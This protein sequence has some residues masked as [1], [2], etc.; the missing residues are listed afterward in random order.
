MAIGAAAAV[1]L[2]YLGAMGTWQAPFGQRL[3]YW[4]VVVLPG[5]LLG[6]FVAV[7]VRFWGRFA[8]YRWL[9]ILI[10]AVAVSV[11]H[12][13]LVIVASALF[14]DVDMITPLVV[15]QFWLVVLVL[16]LVLTSINFMASG[17]DQRAPRPPAPAATPPPAPA[18]AQAAATQELPVMPAS[19][20]QRLPPRLQT[21]RL[22]AIAAEDHYL[23]VHTDLGNDLI[24]MRMTDACA[25]LAD[26]PGARVHRSWWLARAAAAAR[27][28]QDGRMLI[29]LV[30]GQTVPVSRAKQ[31]ELKRDGW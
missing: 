23:R 11:P 25:M 15:V 19:L 20:A 18:A 17:G 5:S 7:L 24:L 14:F 10:V 22:I 3:A 1:L 6:L 27:V 2:A 8:A 4:L 26:V 16:S 21:G 12:S 31:A 13:F 9:E 29:R 30:D 28:V